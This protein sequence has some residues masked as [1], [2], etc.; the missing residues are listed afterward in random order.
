[1]KNRVAF[2]K[3]E[4]RKIGGYTTWGSMWKKGQIHPD[5]TF[6][7]MGEKGNQISAQTRIT[8]FWPDGSVKWAAHTADSSQMGEWVCV[9]KGAYEE[10]TC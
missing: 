4:N 9:E 6:L 8:A 5:D 1:M 7:I 10:Y 2:H 3:L